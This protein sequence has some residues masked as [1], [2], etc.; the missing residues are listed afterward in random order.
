MNIVN[1]PERPAA[2]HLNLEITFTCGLL[3]PAPGV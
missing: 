1:Q 2:A 3:I